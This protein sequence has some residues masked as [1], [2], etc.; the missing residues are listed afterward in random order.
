MQDTVE[1]ISLEHARTSEKVD[2]LQTDLTNMNE[3]HKKSF[4][5]VEEDIRKTFQKVDELQ[6][7]IRKYHETNNQTYQKV[8][9]VQNEITKYHEANSQTIEK[10]NQLQNTISKYQG[11][12]NKTFEK[13]DQIQNDITKYQEATSHTIE[14]VDQLQNVITKYQEANSKIFKAESAVVNAIAINIENFLEGS[15]NTA[16]QMKSD[17]QSLSLEIHSIDEN[18]KEAQNNSFEKLIKTQNNLKSQ[19]KELNS[20]IEKVCTEQ[21]A[22]ISSSIK[23]L[24]KRIEKVD[25]NVNEGKREI[26]LEI[27][28]NQN[29]EAIKNLSSVMI[30][31]KNEIELH[32]ESSLTNIYSMPLVKL[33]GGQT[34]SEGIVYVKGIGAL[35]CHF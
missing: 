20:N 34:S 14:K 21:F 15:K 4:E 28:E 23:V 18:L 26:L 12:N 13:V 1:K 31:N 35:F 25:E 10:V 3:V 32:V 27:A 33:V 2:K 6:N 11:A 17:I 22:A 8:D 24:T 9:T 29:Q 5:K 7:D 19:N 16:D 30:Q